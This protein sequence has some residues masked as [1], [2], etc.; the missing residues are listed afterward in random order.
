MAS[1]HQHRARWRVKWRD[2]H[3]RQLV[4]SYATKAEAEKVARTIEARAVI[5]G[6]PPVIVDPDA[7]TLA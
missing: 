2:E 1:V 7:L 5:D 6:R 4:E 3:G